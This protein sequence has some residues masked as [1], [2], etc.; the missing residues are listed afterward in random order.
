MKR[1]KIHSYD[2]QTQKGIIIP[3]DGGRQLTFKYPGAT[4]LL[5]FQPGDR[6]EYEVSWHKAIHV[7]IYE[8]ADL[9][10]DIHR[11]PH[12][13][14]Y[15]RFVEVERRVEDSDWGDGIETY[16]RKCGAHTSG[17]GRLSDAYWQY[18]DGKMPEQEAMEFAKALEDRNLLPDF[19]NRKFKFR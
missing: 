8:P 15:M 12:C 18:R 14:R 16:C 4:I 17:A 19:L 11:C 9:F 13:R 2:G 6:V 3:D 1:G 7:E 5:M 10:Q